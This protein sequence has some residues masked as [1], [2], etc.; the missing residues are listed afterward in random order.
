MLEQICRDK[1]VDDAWFLN[2][3]S[4]VTYSAS[5]KVLQFIPLK[6]M[7]KYGLVVKRYLEYPSISVE[8]LDDVFEEI[9]Y[10][11][12]QKDYIV[13]FVDEALESDRINLILNISLRDRKV[14]FR[15]WS[16]S[17]EMQENLL[18]YEEYG[19]RYMACGLS[20]GVVRFD[21]YSPV[22]Q[23]EEKKI[24]WSVLQK[25]IQGS[26]ISIINRKRCLSNKKGISASSKVMREW[27]T[28]FQ[29][30]ISQ[31]CGEEAFQL[32]FVISEEERR[33]FQ[34]DTGYD[35]AKHLE[36]MIKVYNKLL[37]RLEKCS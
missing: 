18:P 21:I 28:V 12:Q 11:L 13:H 16:L 4:T 6:E 27:F 31:F 17:G 23:K 5:K 33:L 14:T 29:D 26:R 3:F 2:F 37:G 25:R 20:G 8:E 36:Q 15:S 22:K 1:R 30:V 34:T 7:W 9:Q 32:P 10:Y 24:N 35:D 19:K